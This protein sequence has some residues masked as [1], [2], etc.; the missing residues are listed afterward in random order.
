MS[1]I[2]LSGNAAGSGTLTIASPNTNTDRTLTLPDAAG[3]VVVSEGGSTF[4]VAA[5]NKVG[6]GTNSPAW[7]LHVADATAPIVQLEETSVGNTFV[8]QDGNEF[9]VRKGAIGN[10]DS[11]TVQSDGTTQL[12]RNNGTCL[13]GSTTIDSNLTNGFKFYPQ[14]S[15]GGAF[16]SFV[17]TGN[18]GTNMY[19]INAN[20]AATT[21]NAIAFLK[22]TTVV[23]SIVCG[24][25]STSYGTTSDYRLKEDLQPIA[26]ASSRLAA[27][28]PVNFAW[29]VDGTRTDGFIAHEV[30]AVVPQAVVGEKDAVDD[31]GNPVYQ[32]IDHSKLVPLLTAALQ[33][34]LGR[35]AALE[36]EVA[37]LKGASA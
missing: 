14:G 11:I 9:F 35:I 3:T 4:K 34:A 17:N 25:T 22:S 31:D 16:A 21:W 29:K 12:N 10:Q 5:S 27:L 37:A 28:K 2:T 33:E 36:A 1:R 26:Y 32:G 23:G 13:I 19:I 18:G 30:Q 8:G 15:A 6:I 7:N 24:N 20:G